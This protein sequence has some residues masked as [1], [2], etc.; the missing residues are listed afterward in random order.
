MLWHRA[1]VTMVSRAWQT[2]AHW[3]APGGFFIGQVAGYGLVGLIVGS[4]G[5]GGLRQGVPVQQ[6]K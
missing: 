3:P 2:P 4:C 5:G 6:I 1:I